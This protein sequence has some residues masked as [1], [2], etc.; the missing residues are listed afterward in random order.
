M[1][2]AN[3]L[4]SIAFLNEIYS[5]FLVAASNISGTDTATLHNLAN[6]FTIQTAAD[7]L[8]YKLIDGLRHDDEVKEKIR[9]K[10]GLDK[11]ERSPFMSLAII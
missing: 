3:R 1:T 7:A 10:T 6:N 4:Q 2:P 5:L 11:T 9:L 8:Q